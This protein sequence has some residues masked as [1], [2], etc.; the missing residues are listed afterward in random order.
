MTSITG[1]EKQLHIHHDG[2]VYTVQRANRLIK[3]ILRAMKAAT[4]RIVHGAAS[5]ADRRLVD[6]FNTEHLSK[7]VLGSALDDMER[8]GVS[9]SDLRDL[10]AIGFHWQSDGFKAAQD[11]VTQVED[12]RAA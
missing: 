1:D 11:I 5:K 12:R 9:E 4:E 2:K 3:S 7:T 6:E 8:A 10:T